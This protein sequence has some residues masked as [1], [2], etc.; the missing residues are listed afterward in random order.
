MGFSELTR[1]GEAT[2][3]GEHALDGGQN[4]GGLRCGAGVCRRLPG[5]NNIHDPVDLHRGRFIRSLDFVNL[6]FS[7]RSDFAK[8]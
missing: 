4:I 6:L 8:A 3:D 1:A 2:V 7:T 5:S